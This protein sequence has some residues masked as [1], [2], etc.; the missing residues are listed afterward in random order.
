MSADN[1]GICPRCFVAM[2]NKKISA[3]GK[4]TQ[5]EYLKLL[6][7]EEKIMRCTLREDYEVWT[8]RHGK[9]YLSYSCSCSE[10]GFSYEHKYDEQLVVQC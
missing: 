5:K 7:V 10:C 8:N 2:Q 1:W 6:E 9:F 3:Y 4:I